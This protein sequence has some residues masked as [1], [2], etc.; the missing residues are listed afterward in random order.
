MIPGI[1]ISNA[2]KAASDGAKTVNGPSPLSASLKPAA[3]IAAFNVDTSSV[4][5]TNS[6]ILS[7]GRFSS[8]GS[9]SLQLDSFRKGETISEEVDVKA[10]KGAYFLCADINLA[11]AQEK[12]WTIIRLSDLMNWRIRQSI[13]A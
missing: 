11:P 6:I 8:I 10:E 13:L 12:K 2:A 7:V 9:S 5:S 1:A 3:L 4:W